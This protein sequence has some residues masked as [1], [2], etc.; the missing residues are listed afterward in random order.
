MNLSD[1]HRLA[2]PPRKIDPALYKCICERSIISVLGWVL[3]ALG[4][5][6]SVILYFTYGASLILFACMPGVLGLALIYWGRRDGYVIIRILRDGLVAEGRVVQ[7]E[8]VE[9]GWTITFHFTAEDGQ[10]YHASGETRSAKPFDNALIL[11]NQYEP[12]E[13]F[14]IV[15]QENETPYCV[16]KYGQWQLRSRK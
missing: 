4:C 13:N 6:V 15:P 8:S 3:F 9:G 2:P 12:A 16:D 14:V 7:R 5:I 11:Y 1:I 10:L